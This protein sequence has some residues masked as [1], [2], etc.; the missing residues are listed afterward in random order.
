VGGGYGWD[1]NGAD[2]ASLDYNTVCDD[3]LCWIEPPP[4]SMEKLLVPAHG[5]L[6]KP[7]ERSQSVGCGGKIKMQLTRIA[8]SFAMSRA[9]AP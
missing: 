6:A 5:E 1:G 4:A 3:K 2:D 8:S 9:S 7:F